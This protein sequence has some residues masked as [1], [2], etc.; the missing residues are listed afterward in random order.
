MRTIYTVK[1]F[2]YACD[3]GVPEVTRTKFDNKQEAEE[4]LIWM[5]DEELCDATLEVS[6]ETFVSTP[7]IPF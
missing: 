3:D 2:E 6:H 7:E 5:R 1:V 4:Y